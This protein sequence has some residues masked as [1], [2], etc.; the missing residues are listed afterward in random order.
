MKFIS[1][2]TGLVLAMGIAAPASAE[3][4]LASNP[5][6]L[7]NFFFNQGIPA[8]LTTDQ[9]GDPLVEYRVNGDT[10]QV[11]FYDCTDNTN[12]L[13]LQFSSGYRLDKPISLETVNGW[14]AENRFTFAYLADD[15]A[16]WIE[17]DIATSQDGISD[18]DF[19]DIYDLWVSNLAD[20]EKTIGW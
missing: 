10:N 13:A 15:G 14:N 7:V 19:K 18:R 11:Y 3:Q 2:A 1:A 9:V 5:Q 12:C 8:Q 4:I 16:V 6:S 17:F 20:F